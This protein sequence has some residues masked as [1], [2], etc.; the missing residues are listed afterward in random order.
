MK[1]APIVYKVRKKEDERVPI[2]TC[3]H[4]TQD[5]DEHLIGVFLANDAARLSQNAT[6]DEAIAAQVQP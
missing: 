5:P 2:A 4:E 6:H 1:T 3:A